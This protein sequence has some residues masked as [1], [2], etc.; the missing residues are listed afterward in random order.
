MNRLISLGILATVAF[1]QQPVRGDLYGHGTRGLI[2]AHGGRFDEKSWRKQAEVFANSGFLVFA[3]HFRGDRHNPDGS[4]SAEGSTADNATDVLTAASHLRQLGATTIYAVGGSLGGDAVG[5]AD[6]RAPG[7]ISRIV[8]LGSSGPDDPEK[9]T[10]RKLF[11]VA[12]DDANDAGPRL[13]GITKSYERT[14]QPKRLV[15]LDGSAHAQFLFDTDQGPHLLG[16]ILRF[17][18]AP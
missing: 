3:L 12:R 2:L 8:F 15:I 11:I 1:A 4:P 14:H 9:L 5:E 7:A 16:E 6:V 13:P 10:G 18:T 17:L